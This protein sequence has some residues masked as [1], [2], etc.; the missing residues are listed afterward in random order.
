MGPE[1]RR[2]RLRG[3]GTGPDPRPSEVGSQ[4]LAG[5]DRLAGRA[6]T[7]EKGG[8]RLGLEGRRWGL[9]LVCG[10][11]FGTC[12]WPP[13]CGSSGERPGLEMEMKGL[14]EIKQENR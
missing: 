8:G 11:A 1:V 10:K 3:S 2:P 6:I 14:S 4:A 13:V 5:C 7:R 9:E 12:K